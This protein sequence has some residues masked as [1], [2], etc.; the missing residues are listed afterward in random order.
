M[1][2]P[3]GRYKDRKVWIWRFGKSGITNAFSKD[4]LY[5]TI[6]HNTPLLAY[7]II[8]SVRSICG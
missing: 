8:L 4:A 7:L 2:A 5:S 1:H 6:L 3:Y